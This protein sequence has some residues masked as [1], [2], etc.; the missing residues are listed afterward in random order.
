MCA[1]KTTL[2]DVLAYRKTAGKVSGDVR[3][4]GV[5]VNR[6]TLAR[7]TGYCEQEDIHLPTATVRE[8]LEFSCRLRAPVPK[9]DGA[10]H[11]R[12]FIN[13]IIYVLELTELQNRLV[14]TL[15]KNESKRVTI[16][17][18]LASCPSLLYV[19]EVSALCLTPDILHALQ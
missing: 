8:A 9:V 14:G 17:V 12:I 3:L 5:P 16:G 7:V 15:S 11:L 19:D 1:G 13:R 2:L 10:N 18:E 4:N 6:K